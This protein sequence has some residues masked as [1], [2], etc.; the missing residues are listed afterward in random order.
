MKKMKKILLNSVK[1]YLRDDGVYSS[2]EFSIAGMAIEGYFD[3]MILRVDKE[4]S[5]YI[6]IDLNTYTSVKIIP[7]NI[8]KIT[9]DFIEIVDSKNIKYYLKRFP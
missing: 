2:Y 8:T 5:I 6:Q 1:G 7:R 4:L 3:S 9:Y